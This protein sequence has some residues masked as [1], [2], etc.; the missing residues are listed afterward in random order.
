MCDFDTPKLR[1]LDKLPKTELVM[2]RA[3]IETRINQ[4][5]TVLEEIE[6]IMSK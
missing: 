3:S 1:E 5:L 6:N 2:I 4:L